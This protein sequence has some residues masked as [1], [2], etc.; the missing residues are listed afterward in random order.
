MTPHILLALGLASLLLFLLTL[1]GAIMS[2]A[3]Q[4]RLLLGLLAGC[5]LLVVGAFVLALQTRPR[6]V[7]AHSSCLANLKQLEGAKATW[8]LEFK[9]QPTDLPTDRDLFGETQYIR[10]KPTCP[11]GGMYRIGAVNE[12]AACS[13]GGPGH[14]LEE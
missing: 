12:K 9:K 3:R 14:R 11:Q 7:S 10:D 13:L 5:S 6:V 4:Q 1:A 8:A 2:K